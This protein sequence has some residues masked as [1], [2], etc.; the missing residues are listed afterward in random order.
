MLSQWME[1]GKMAYLGLKPAQEIHNGFQLDGLLPQLIYMDQRERDQLDQNLQKTLR[2]HMETLLFLDTNARNPS[3]RVIVQMLDERL[4]LVVDAHRE[5]QKKRLS[6]KKSVYIKPVEQRQ[7]IDL[8]LSKEDQMLLEQENEDLVRE[9]EEEM[10]AEEA[11]RAL[12]EITQMQQVL[13][14]HLTQ[15]AEMVDMISGDVVQVLGNVEKGK[16]Q[17]QSAKKHFGGVRWWILYVFVGASLLL[18]LLD[19]IL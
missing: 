19:R 12:H 14:Q 4:K 1:A 15:Q 5:M 6:T 8:E 13:G 18:L 10:Q 7:F 11:A 17:L 16:E 9:L 3:E 2:Q